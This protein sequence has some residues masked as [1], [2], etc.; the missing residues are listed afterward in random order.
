ME[1]DESYYQDV[2]AYRLLLHSHSLRTSKAFRQLH[3][4]NSIADTVI[5]NGHGTVYEI[6]SDLD[7]FERLEGQLKDYF[8]VFSY[9]NVVIPEEKL[10]CLRERL[11][12]MPEFGRHVG[13][14]VLTRRNAL[15]KVQAPDEYNNDLSGLELLKMLRKPEYSAI[16]RSEFGMLPDVPP[17]MF[18]PACRKMF[19]DIPVL[20]AQALV[21]A[22]IKQRNA[23]TR[24]DLERFPEAQRISLYFSY[25]K[26]QQVPRRKTFRLRMTRQGGCVMTYY[27]YL[28]ARQYELFAL[29]ELLTGGLL[30]RDVVPIIEPV[31]D[32]PQL[33]QVIRLFREREGSALGVVL[34]PNMGEL[35]SDIDLDTKL[36]IYGRNESEPLIGA[37]GTVSPV[38]LLNKDAVEVA[39]RV[40]NADE[41]LLQDDGIVF[42]SE[43]DRDRIGDLKKFDFR[44]VAL[45]DSE[46][47]N[48]DLKRSGIRSRRILFSDPFIKRENN[49]AYA[50]DDHA[51]EFF[52][53]DHL[54]YEKEGY[55][56]FGDYSI[57]GD[58]YTERGGMPKAVALHIVYFDDEWTL[59]IHHFV[60]EVSDDAHET[61]MKFIETA[62]QLDSW[63]EAREGLPYEHMT[64]GMQ[65]LINHAKTGTYPGLPT[66]KKLSIMHHLQLMSWFLSER[67]DR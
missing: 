34:N 67:P 22:A 47:L 28:R 31:R 50:Q 57:V 65:T 5:I 45:S 36:D 27:P 41:S 10:T 42:V 43:S 1:R 63:H 29:R 51:D 8:K 35:T 13:V 44:A 62:R 49:A 3:V 53:D 7:T 32:M 61:P 12:V 48:R 40:R 38:I 4:A 25:D 52:S 9:V 17:A 64:L 11:A 19:L 39:E 46:R 54:W 18:Y 20:K 26:M 16:L 2:V 33:H 60:S 37:A 56:G 66:I 59:R 30:S 21:M 23:W 15:K 6:K 58:N 55:V 24:E 14:Y